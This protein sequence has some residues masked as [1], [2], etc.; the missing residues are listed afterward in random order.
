V[1]GQHTEGSTEG[2]VDGFCSGRADCGA[3]SDVPEPV[4]ADSEALALPA[5]RISAESG[6]PTA[7]SSMLASANACDAALW[8]Q[9]ADFRHVSGVRCVP[10]RRG[11]T[12][13]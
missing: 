12:T 3:R 4:S 7:D 10:K 8:T 1:T 2:D 5:A 13:G 6:R 11:R 9:D